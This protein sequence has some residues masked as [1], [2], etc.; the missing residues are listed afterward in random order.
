LLVLIGL[1][2]AWMF[3]LPWDLRA[4]LSWPLVM[5]GPF[6]VLAMAFGLISSIAEIVARHRYRRRTEREAGSQ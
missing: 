1:G 6:L 3:T 5:F 2:A 4:A